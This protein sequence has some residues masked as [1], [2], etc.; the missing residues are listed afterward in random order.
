MFSRGASEK[1]TEARRLRP[2]RLPMI[3]L[4]GADVCLNR[5][6]FANDFHPAH[7][8]PILRR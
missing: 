6:L 8:G 3:F 2:G 1:M 7:C 5:V 4:S